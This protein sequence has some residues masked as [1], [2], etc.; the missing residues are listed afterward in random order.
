MPFG[1]GGDDD[2]SG[3]AWLWLMNYTPTF[4]PSDEWITNLGEFVI[5]DTGD[6]IVFNG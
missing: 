3:F 5:T 6:N 2:D 1:F 4:Y